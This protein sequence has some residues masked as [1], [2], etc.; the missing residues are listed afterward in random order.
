[1]QGKEVRELTG[2]QRAPE[3]SRGKEN[4]CCILKSW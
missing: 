4:A 3:V 1:M 2:I